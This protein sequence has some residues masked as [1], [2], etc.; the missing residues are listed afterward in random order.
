M[1]LL[2]TF[3][4]TLSA[5][6]AIAQEISIRRDATPAS[7]VVRLGD[8]AE[9]RGA[10]AARNE[11]LARLPLMPAPAAGAKR[12]VR[13]REIEDMLVALGEDVQQLRF[14]GALQVAVQ[15]PLAEPARFMPQAAASATGEAAPDALSDAKAARQ[16]A[17][18]RGRVSGVHDL[19]QGDERPSPA[20]ESIREAICNYLAE[21]T[22]AAEG[23]EIKFD[24]SERQQRLLAAATSPVVCSGGQAPW[25]GQQLFSFTCATSPGPAILSV[26][27]EVM[28]SLRV[29]GGQ[30]AI[31][32]GAIITAADVELRQMEQSTAANSRRA[33]LT[34]ID[35]LIGME[36][37][38]AIPIGDVIYSDQVRAPLLVK[39]GEQVTVVAQGGGI[40]VRTAARAAQEG[41]RGELVQ[42]ESL[43]TKEKYDARVTG[44]R[45]V[46][47]LAPPR[48]AADP[49]AEAAAPAKGFRKYLQASDS[50]RDSVTREAH[51]FRRYMKEGG[52][53][54][55]QVR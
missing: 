36:A 50:P 47:V 39:R 21:Q 25:T 24:L 10:D 42:V 52:Q 28:P 45:E 11:Q 14:S 4:V 22:G 53:P 32:R 23:W 19:P 7:T 33:P 30:R 31:A 17:L 44:L 46:S 27:A 54:N 34:T 16:L 26:S 18:A 37:G 1:K 3:L 2:L 55:A 40:R 29:V 5:G 20:S 43:E 48:S 9:I 38:R 8:V 41:A 35:E 49:A 13:R 12:F 6:A 15:S 51:A